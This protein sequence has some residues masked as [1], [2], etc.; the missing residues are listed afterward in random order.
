MDHGARQ[1]DTPRRGPGRR[2]LTR[3]IGVALMAG[4][5][6]GAAACSSKNASTTT[7]TAA[8]TTT[9]NAATAQTDIGTAFA[10]VFNLSDPSL[11]PKLAA[12]QNGDAIQTAFQQALSSSL[13]K[14]A[15]GAKIDSVKIDT[16]AECAK[17]PVP[18]P[19][20]HVVYD[21][22]G[23]TGTAVLANSQGYAVDVNGQWLVAKTTICG[24]LGLFYQAEGNTGSP[25]GC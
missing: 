7:T 3:T 17:V 15:A 23:P 14:S 9:I 8:P 13:A 10:T 12:I 11:A 2:R 24:L 16:A 22:N 21:I 19:C 18:S 20:A 5:A 1:T 4:I 6:L 25:T